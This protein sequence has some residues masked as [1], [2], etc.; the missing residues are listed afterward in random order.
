MNSKAS[1]EEDICSDIFHKESH[2]KRYHSDIKCQ[3]TLNTISS[4]V[5]YYNE[6]REPA[7]TLDMIFSVTSSSSRL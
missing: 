1:W 4:V 2:H 5:T 7:T 3:M 6:R